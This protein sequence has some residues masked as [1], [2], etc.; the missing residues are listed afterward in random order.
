VG[1]ALTG[2]YLKDENVWAPGFHF[3][4]N[5]NLG[6]SRFGLG[7]NYERLIDEHGHHALDIVLKYS[8]LHS[9][10]VSATPGLSFSGM[11]PF[12]PQGVIHIEA[13]YEIHVHRICIDPVVEAAFH[14][15]ETHLSA[16]VHLG[17]LF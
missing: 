16:G 8:L 9:L 12:K 17:L 5:R 10:S 14:A 7:A 3:H 6:N 13:A 1:I 11:K 2:A 15:D 4:Y